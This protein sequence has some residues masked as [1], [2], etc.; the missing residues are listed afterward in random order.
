[1]LRR[2][3]A[4]W[5]GIGERLLGAASPSAPAPGPVVAAVAPNA[6]VP[7]AVVVSQRAAAHEGPAPVRLHA[8]TGSTDLDAYRARARAAGRDPDLLA[9][10]EGVNVAA[11]RHRPRT[12]RW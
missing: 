2:L 1:M 7:P 4:R 11:P 10:G 9:G 6:G 3:R 12:T 8:D 5:D